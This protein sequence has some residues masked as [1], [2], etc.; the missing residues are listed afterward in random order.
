MRKQKPRNKPAPAAKKP[1]KNGATK[2]ASSKG[3]DLLPLLKQAAD[4]SRGVL[5]NIINSGTQLPPELR[6]SPQMEIQISPTPTAAQVGGSIH[7]LGFIPG[8]CAE[9][10]WNAGSLPQCYAHEVVG[11]LAEFHRIL[12]VGGVL[13]L[14]L[15]DLQRIAESVSQGR[16]EQA[17]YR[18]PAGSITA[19]DLIY[20]HTQSIAEGTRDRAAK[21]GF[22]AGSI[23][24]KITRAGFGEVDVWR[25]GWLLM[26]R[27]RKVRVAQGAKPV[28]RIHDEDLNLKM[29]KRDTIE[30]DP[31]I[32]T[33]VK[34]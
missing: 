5:L 21:T 32:W 1:V 9:I 26:V 23:A 15:P 17:L 31:E 16:L 29:Q 13:C 3:A 24:S 19:L 6:K 28:I 14:N 2:T 10:I 30:K 7:T 4:T 8:K 33:E 22:T 27:A 34:I 25:Q 20:G 11:V 12:K 18:S